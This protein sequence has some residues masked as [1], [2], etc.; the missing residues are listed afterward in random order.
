MKNKILRLVLPLM[1]LP[2]LL[3]QLLILYA[4][5]QA[6]HAEAEITTVIYTPTTALFPNPER[7]FYHH[8]ETYSS[9]FPGEGSPFSL[10]TL[11]QHRQDENISLILRLYYLNSFTT[12]SISPDYL[13]FIR[14]EMAIIRQAGLKVVLRFAYSKYEGYPN[15]QDASFT[16]V[17]THLNEL[18]PIFRENSDVIAVVQA[19]FIGAYGEWHAAH[20]DFGPP[21]DPN[22]GTR[23]AVLFKLLAGLPSTRMVQLR[24]PR[25]KYNI[26]SDTVEYS[27]TIP[28]VLTPVNSIQA[29]QGSNVARTGHHNDCFLSS[30][31]DYGTYVYT[32]TELPYLE[33]ETKY[34]V[35]GGE[36]CDPKYAIDPDPSR[37]EC[38]NAL[39]EME[40]FHWS[41]LNRDWYT[42][43]LQ[44]WQEN[45]CFTEIEQRLGYR[46][47]LLEGSYANEVRAGESFTFS[48]KLRNEGWAAPFNPR[49]V[50]LLLRHTGDGSFYPVTLPDDPRFWLA[51]GHITYTLSHTL[52]IPV[53]LPPGDYELLLHLPDPHPSLSGRPEYAIR[54]A[55][56]LVWENST[57]YNRLLHTLKVHEPIPKVYL[58]LILHNP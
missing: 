40:R 49:L 24:T 46:F 43:T 32:P 14:Q 47:V 50:K 34:V 19:G 12:T 25:Y 39:A 45:G 22:Y 28:I 21:E 29:H 53:D 31:S 23:G 56:E 4:L 57:G 30:T 18:E 35:M 33:A 27:G 51:D 41:Y 13:N 11:Q 2:A 6:T 17:I 9:N 5:P 54:F 55:N 16:Q 15:T 36:T 37:L 52:S 1:A 42:P 20:S 10:T 58:P 38:Q 26:F 3:S 7:G 44:S 48:L 8:Y